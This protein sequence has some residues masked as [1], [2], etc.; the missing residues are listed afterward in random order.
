MKQ[1]GITAK[2]WL[3]IGVF[4]F[5]FV[6]AAVLGQVQGL[7]IERNLKST[8]MALFPAA[9]SSQDAEAAFQRM[10]KSYGDAVLTQDASALDHADEEGR[11][12]VSSLK[13]IAAIDGL[14]ATRRAEA[15]DIAASVD[16]FA[17]EARSV[18]G[19][20]LT[21]PSRM[22]ELQGHVASLASR[23]DVIKS[24][25]QKNRENLAKDLRDE[26]QDLETRSARQRWTCI[27]MLGLT[28]G[29]SV[30]IV[31]TTLRRAVTRPVRRVIEG[32]QN[33]ANEA[34]EASGQMTKSG[35]TVAHDA[36]QQAVYLQETSASLA[37]ISSTTRANA[38]Q[39]RQADG[40][41]HEAT[42][43]VRGALNTMDDLTQSMNAISHSSREVVAVLRSLDQIAFQTNILAL[44]AAVEAAR[45]GEFG[46][47]FSVVA[48]EVRSLARRSAESAHQSAEIVEKTIADVDR[49]V[50]LVARAHGAFGAISRTIGDGSRMVSQIAANSTEQ[51]GGISRIE[52]ALAKIEHVTQSNA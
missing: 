3:S 14:S 18:Y 44:N 6:M 35:K 11:T 42:E 12:V 48:D 45:A 8:A 38:D 5:G 46:A 33:A 20:L 31:N 9:Q 15:S 27:L 22:S 41:M 4:V 49:G 2:I 29:V 1:L 37:E 17:S 32:M 16:S 36:E 39:A 28:L 23:T 26:L 47:G 30:I 50:E 40:F 24:G 52:E 51:A 19:E 43:T 34:A 7:S 10:V 13:S 25:L 21:N